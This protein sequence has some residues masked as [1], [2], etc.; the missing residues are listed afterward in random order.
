[1]QIQDQVSPQ[2]IAE[3]AREVVARLRMQMQQPASAPAAASRDGV[4][5]TVDEAASAAFEAQKKVAAMSFDDRKRIIDIIC[6]ICNDRREE[7]GRMELEETKVGRLD[8]KILKLTNMRFVLGVDAMRTEARSNQTGLCI[9]EHAPWG[10]IGMML[11]VTHSVPTMASNA[12]NIIAAGNTA[13]FGPHPSGARVARYAL[14]LWNREIER[15]LGVANVLTTVAEASIEAAEQIFHHPKIALLCVTGGAAVAKA[16][17]KSG[18]RVIAG[19]PGNPP[20]VVDETANLDRAAECIIAGAAFDNNLLCIGEKEV[21]VVASVADAFIAA[22]R[23]AGAYQL[24]AAA[25]DKLTRAAFTFE[26]G[27]GGCARAHVNKAFVGKDVSVLAAAAGVSVPASTELL[28]GETDENHAFVVEEQMMP[29]IPI[30]RVPNV[31]AAIA[32]AVKAE[33]GYRHTAVIHTQNVETA[34]RMA[35]VMNTTLFLH[36]AASPASLGVGGPGYFSHT[37]ATPT[38]EGITTPLT[39]TRER[40]MVVGSALRII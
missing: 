25:I 6:R 18:K 37:I 8:H 14:Q 27:G 29:F 1:M 10:V 15:E 38:G 11:P 33:H 31:D 35:R 21:F 28:F 2:V 36:N 7:L 9:I 34:T 19:G 5:A 23:R 4:F 20:V 39:F 17:A 40:Q 16:A 26:G 12:I 13:V 32:A 3:I 30:V 24:D 22:M